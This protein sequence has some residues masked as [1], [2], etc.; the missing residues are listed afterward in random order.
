MKAQGWERARGVGEG[1]DGGCKEGDA[2]AELR[3]PPRMG[4]LGGEG[5]VTGPDVLGGKGACSICC[6]SPRKEPLTANPGLE[7]RKRRLERLIEKAEKQGK[8]RTLSLGAASVVAG[9]GLHPAPFLSSQLPAARW[10]RAM[11]PADL[12]VPGTSSFVC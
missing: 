11:V 1:E 2:G 6:R 9:R 8:T 7:V 3:R 5:Q 10:Y 4:R 12:G